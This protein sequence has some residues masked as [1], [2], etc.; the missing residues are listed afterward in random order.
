MPR[1]SMQNATGPSDTRSR[2]WANMNYAAPAKIFN[3]R[4]T[5]C[6]GHVNVSEHDSRSREMSLA[7]SR[8]ASLPATRRGDGSHSILGIVSY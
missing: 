1:S 4:P 6:S 7:S 8:P 3:C 2:S 5:D